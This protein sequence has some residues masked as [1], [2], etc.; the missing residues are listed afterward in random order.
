MKTFEIFTE[1]DAE[2]EVWFVVKSDV[3]GLH[4]EA[5]TQAEMLEV[6]KDLIPELVQANVLSHSHQSDP[7]KEV[8]FSLIARRDELVAISY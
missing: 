3:P 7:C 4:A 6:L 5:A 2:A 8:P 1:W